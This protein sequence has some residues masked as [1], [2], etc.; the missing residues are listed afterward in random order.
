M[1][2]Q[3]IFFLIAALTLVNGIFSPMTMIAAQLWPVW[4]PG[5]IKP[6]IPIISYG[7]MLLTSLFTLVMSGLPA[8]VSERVFAEKL[9]PNL[10]MWIWFGTAF[11]ISIPGLQSALSS[12]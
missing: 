6:T 2:R 1:E 12:F 3:Q 4:L 11:M 7:S 9:E 8:A 5:Y 10:I